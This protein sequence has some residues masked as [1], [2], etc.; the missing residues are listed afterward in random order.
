V[1]ASRH[2]AMPMASRVNGTPTFYIDGAC[3]DGS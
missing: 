2:A 1:N 3:Y